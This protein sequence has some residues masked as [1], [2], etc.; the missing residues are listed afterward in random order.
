MGPLRED[1]REREERKSP[2]P[3]PQ[4]PQE[5]QG[6]DHQ[7]HQVELH[8]VPDRSRRRSRQKVRAQGRAKKFREGHKGGTGQAG[9]RVVKR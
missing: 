7:L 8:Q 2:L 9:V 3:I 6:P 1:G 4:V 5:R